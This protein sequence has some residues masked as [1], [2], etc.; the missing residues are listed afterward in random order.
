MARKDRK[1]N[2][3]VVTLCAY[4]CISCPVPRMNL[5]LISVLHDD[6]VA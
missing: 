5:A 1:V 2:I 6:P 3:S 4:N